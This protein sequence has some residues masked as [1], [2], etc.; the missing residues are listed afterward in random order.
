MVIGRV[1]LRDQASVWYNAVLRGDVH[2]IVIGERT[3]IQDLSMLHATT[4]VSPTI[5]GNDVTVGHRAILHGC[6]I[7]HTSLIG[8]GA[9]ILDEAE[10]G[11]YSLVGAGALVTPGKKYPAR[12][13][14]LGSPGKVVRETTDA[15][16]EG[17]L[18]SARHYVEMAQ[19]HQ[20][21]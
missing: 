18:E 17:F 6:S 15:E 21:K 9:I 10:I 11:E 12:S 4:G 13:V 1:T 16:I 2:D 7:G 8:M 20:N 5:I 19:K 14:I 3:N